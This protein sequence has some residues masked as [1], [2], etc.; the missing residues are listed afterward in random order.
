M[1]CICLLFDVLVKVCVIV[2]LHQKFHIYLNV[3]HL[4][5]ILIKSDNNHLKA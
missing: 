5:L 2:F 1:L 3:F 4:N